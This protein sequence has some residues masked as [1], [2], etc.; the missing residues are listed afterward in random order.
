MMRTLERVTGDAVDA[1]RILPLR[2]A[3]TSQSSRT[4]VLVETE[5]LLADSIKYTLEREGYR[6]VAPATLEAAIDVIPLERPELILLEIAGAT[7]EALEVCRTVRAS[8]T[9]PII[10]L[11]LAITDAGRADAFQA[12]ADDLLIKPFSVRELAHRVA[13]QM[14]RER[15]SARSRDSDLD[16]LS[17]GPVEMDVANHEVK[18]RGKLT[19]FPPKEF[20]LLERQSARGCK[21]PHFS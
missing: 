16:L 1:A 6:I 2:V 18:V 11:T 15:S 21:T 9:A 5:P 14:R 20:G 7:P 4:I 8:T 3:E 10:I 19:V 12:G 17:V 13:D